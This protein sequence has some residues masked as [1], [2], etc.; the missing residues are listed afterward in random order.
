MLHHDLLVQ[1]KQK[2]AQQKFEHDKHVKSMVTVRD[3]PVFV[4]DRPLDHKWLPGMIER[5]LHHRT[6]KVALLIDQLCTG[7]STT[8]HSQMKLIKTK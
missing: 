5:C 4:C 3:D 2:Q 6:F 8:L 1:V 7:I